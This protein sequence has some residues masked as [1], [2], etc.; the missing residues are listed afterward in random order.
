MGISQGRPLQGPDTHN[1]RWSWRRIQAG[2]TCEKSIWAEERVWVRVGRP[3]SL[4]VTATGE[5]VPCLRGYD[6]TFRAS[7]LLG[8]LWTFNFHIPPVVSITEWSINH[9][10]PLKNHLILAIIY[11]ARVWGKWPYEMGEQRLVDPPW[12]HLQTDSLTAPPPFW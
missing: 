1:E 9:L 10:T 5:V 7:E 4:L 3:R 8:R 11:V 12:G 6:P 2:K